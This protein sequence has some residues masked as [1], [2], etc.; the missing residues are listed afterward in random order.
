MLSRT[1]PLMLASQFGHY[2]S[3]LL[4]L[5]LGAEVHSKNSE[6]KTAIELAA[7]NGFQNIVQLLQ[8]KKREFTIST[9]I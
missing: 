8:S 3:V 7:D 6:G 4:L 5:N 9:L 2:Q 1:T